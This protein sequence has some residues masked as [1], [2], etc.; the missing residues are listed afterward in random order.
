MLH[1]IFRNV[2]IPTPCLPPL[3]L[4]EQILTDA[5]IVYFMLSL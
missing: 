2:K 4:P 3:S 5:L 1:V